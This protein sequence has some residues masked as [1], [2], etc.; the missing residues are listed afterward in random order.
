VILLASSAAAWWG[1]RSIKQGRRG[2]GVLGLAA[3]L[4]LGL[5]FVGV[6]LAEWGSKTFGISDS[7]YGSIYFTLTGF[8]MAHVVVGLAALVL[9]LLWTALG[10]FDERRHAPITYGIAYWHF[11]DAVWICVFLTVYVSPQL[12]GG[13]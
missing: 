11:V 6:Q 4:L 8:H 3:A 7:S 5:V 12:G 2:G 10:Y 1:E 13:R 9:L